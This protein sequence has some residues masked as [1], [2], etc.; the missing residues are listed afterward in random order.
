MNEWTNAEVKL[1]KDRQEKE[2]DK[3]STA[4]PA[5]S[6]SGTTCSELMGRYVFVPVSLS[7]AFQIDD[8]YY[9]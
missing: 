8:S 1:M 5:K 9:H 4:K 7:A 2:K 3:A 6:V